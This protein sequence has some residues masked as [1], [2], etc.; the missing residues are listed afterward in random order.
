MMLKFSLGMLFTATLIMASAVWA[1]SSSA[2]IQEAAQTVTINGTVKAVAASTLTVV[3]DQKAE[4]NI[5]LDA[6]TKITRAGK[7]A[8][9]A[10]LK[11]DDSV[12]VVAT[13]GEGGALIAVRVAVA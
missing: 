7:A 1:N 2:S 3:D 11:A 5:G 6:T 10:D 4:Y 8:T 12:V 9:A 13:K